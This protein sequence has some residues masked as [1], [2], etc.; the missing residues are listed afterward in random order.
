MALSGQRTDAERRAIS[1]DDG[2]IILDWGDRLNE[3]R[4]LI[5]A[6]LDLSTAELALKLEPF[7]RC[8]GLLNPLQRGFFP[9]GIRALLNRAQATHVKWIDTPSTDRL[10]PRD[11]LSYLE[12]ALKRLHLGSADRTQSPSVSPTLGA[13]SRTALSVAMI[14]HVGNSVLVRGGLEVLLDEVAAALGRRG[15]HVLRRLDEAS[16]TPDLF[17]FVGAFYGLSGAWEAAAGFP[18][19]L[20]P[21]LLQS[22]QALAWWRRFADRARSRLPWSLLRSRRKMLEEADLVITSS[23]AEESDAKD[24]G[25]R[26]TAVLLGGVDQR[27]L[28]EAPSPLEKLPPEWQERARSWGNRDGRLVSVGRFVQA[29]GDDRLDV[30]VDPPR[31]VVDWALAE[32]Q[33]HVLATRHE[34]IGL[35]SLEAASLGARPVAIDQPT[36]RDYLLPFGEL[37]A[38]PDPADL[39]R[40][41]ERALQR[42]RLSEAEKALLGNLTWDAMAE[43]LE[44]HYRSILEKRAEQGSRAGG[45]R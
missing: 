15:I 37:A 41:I 44:K 18:R 4:P 38:S 10:M 35:V 21:V 20:F 29:T 19:V 39:T 23:A 9:G 32:S 22:D 12:P 11:L 30:W 31:A 42:G 5:L 33:V 14:G 16:A 1:G 24:L 3:N 43:V 45:M 2:F 8:V 17:H 26:A 28:T 7:G 6:A 25:A 40:A 34:T 13:G 27:R 36:S